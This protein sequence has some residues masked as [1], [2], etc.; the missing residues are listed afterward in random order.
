M[1]ITAIETLM[2][3]GGWRPW[4]FLKVSTD[5]GIT[6]YGECSD[7]RS[8]MSIVGAVEDLKPALIGTDRH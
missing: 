5:D 6:G 1:K 4:I 8:P 3:D 2:V 7:V